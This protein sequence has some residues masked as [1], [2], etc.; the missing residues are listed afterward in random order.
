MI[1]FITSDQ[2]HESPVSFFINFWFH[3]AHWNHCMYV[4]LSNSHLNEFDAWS[5]WFRSVDSRSP[6]TRNRQSRIGKRVPRGRIEE[7]T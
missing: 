5:F 2:K 7:F 1:H 3:L 6:I 4:M